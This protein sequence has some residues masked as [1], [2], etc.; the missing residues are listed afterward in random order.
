MR[1]TEVVATL[2]VGCAVLSAAR[3]GSSA[4]LADLAGRIDYGFYNNDPHAIDAA[5]AA[6]QQLGDGP[7]AQYYRDYA[8]LRRAQLGSTG[9]AAGLIRDCAEREPAPDA[10]GPAAAEAWILAAA[11]GVVGQQSDRHVEQ[12]LA[13]AREL[14]RRNP[15]IGLVEAWAMRS[16]GHEDASA[17]ERLAAKLEQTIAAFDAWHAPPDAPDW[18]EAEALAARGELALA[19]GEVRVARDLIERA[20]LLAPDYSVAV[21]LRA[22][23]HGR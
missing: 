5:R 10:K 14:D 9:R 20:L 2:V 19:R 17:A 8:V 13:H 16:D 11:C 23:L 15:R 22:R 18:G 4:E 3:A 21:E 7:G 12:A 1:L 6:L